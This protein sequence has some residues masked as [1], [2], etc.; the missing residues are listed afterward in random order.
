MVKHPN[1]WTLTALIGCALPLTAQAQSAGGGT[2]SIYGFLK[3]NVEHVR[4]SGNGP[5]APSL[6]VSRLSNDLSVLGF[7]SREDLGGGMSAWAQFETNVRVDTGDGPFGGRNTAVG[8]ATPLGELVLGQWEAP[9]RF[10]SVYAIDPFTAGIFASN[11]IMGNGFSTAANGQSPASFDRRQPNLVQYWSPDMGAWALRLAYA[12]PEEKTS[13][14]SPSMLGSLLT[15]KQGPLYAAWGYERHNSYFYAGSLD[16]AH[17]LAAAYSFGPTRLR[18]SWE[19]L[20]YQ[21][22]PGQSLRRDA[23]QLAVTHQIDDKQE[24]QASFVKAGSAHGNATKQIGGIGIAGTDSGANQVSLGYLYRLSKRTELWT[25]YTRI[26]NGTTA[27]YNLSAN[28]ISGMK[29]GQS[30]SGVGLG[31]THRF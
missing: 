2:L 27:A 16:E 15:Y 5:G 13:Q 31:V 9:L 17:R 29:P 21:P 20:S 8:L 11:S 26:H 19:R 10:T 4:A 30:P 3:T 18:A 7:R 22:A 24:L 14:S 6:S 28:S 25:A 1:N 12:M 23:W